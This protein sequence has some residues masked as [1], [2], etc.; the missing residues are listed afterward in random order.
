MKQAWAALAMGLAL[1][2]SAAANV[3]I[4]D[5][6]EPFSLKDATSGKDVDLKAAGGAKATV[7]MFIATQCPVSNAYNERMAAVA[8]DY[9]G[10]GVAFLGINS[11]KTEPVDEIASHAKQHGLA[12]PV[13]KDTDNI[14]ADFFGA[15]KTPEIFVYDANWKLRYHGSIDDS[16]NVAAV[17]TQGLRAALDA[18]VA[19]KDVAVAETR[20]FGCSIKRVARAASAPKADEAKTSAPAK[21]DEKDKTTK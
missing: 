21:V 19:G 13:L 20:A 4:G 6:L 3:A 1:A 8:K 5:K 10:K 14:Q 17:K 16:Q 9:A 18:L 7:L 11:N 12:F 2:S 15:T